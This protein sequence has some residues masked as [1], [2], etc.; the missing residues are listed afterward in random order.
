MLF[1]LLVMPLLF[2]SEQT[3]HPGRASG[4]STS[5]SFVQPL[6]ESRGAAGPRL[7]AGP[8]Q[9]SAQGVPSRRILSP[10]GAFAE[11]PALQALRSSHAFF[12]TLPCCCRPASQESTM[13]ALGAWAP[14]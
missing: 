14:Q 11:Y 5:C 10:L 7:G 8:R 1:P 3:T 2:I 4:R 9:G 12:P 13:W 6:R